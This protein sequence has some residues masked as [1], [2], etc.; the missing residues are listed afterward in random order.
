M[1][2]IEVTGKTIEEAIQ[3][4]LQELGKTREQVE[5]KIIEIPAKGFLGLIGTKM[6]KVKLTVIDRP[7][8]E[9]KKFLQE[10]FKGM[11]ID[12]EIEADLKGDKLNIYLEGSNMG[13]VIGRRGQTLD[14]V[15]YLTSLVVNKNRE[16]YLKV[17]IDTENYRKKR[18]ETLIKLANKMARKAKKMGKSITLEPMN[19]YERRIIHATLQN[20]PFVQTY[21]EGEEPYRK[22]AITVKR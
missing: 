14:A 4:G 16:N 3:Q 15:Q 13:V 1:K 12:S 18:E 9:A 5:V 10:M 17:F 8:E 21:S 22:V 6:A 20:N 7:E 11:G 19:P 2:S